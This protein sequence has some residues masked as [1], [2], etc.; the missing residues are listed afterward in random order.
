MPINIKCNLCDSENHID[1]KNIA[2]HKNIVQCNRCGLIF[3]N[4]MPDLETIKE[5]L[6]KVPVVSEVELKVEENKYEI[7]LEEIGSLN[8]NQ[9][10][11][12]LDI[13]CGFG[14]LLASAKK[15]GWQIFGL[16]INKFKVAFASEKLGI[17]IYCGELKE[18]EYL[19]DSFEV[20]TV[21]EV[22]EHLINPSG[23]LQ[24]INRILKKDGILVIVVPNVESFNAKTDPSWW[25]SYHFFHFSTNSL[26]QILKKNNLEV[27]KIIINPHLETRSSQRKLFLRKVIF[28][29]FSWGVVFIRK[30][31]SMRFVTKLVV[32]NKLM[33]TGGL[34]VYAKKIL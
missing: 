33:K 29:Y 9:K 3:T 26:T 5:E 15:R 1:Y 16:E 21:I 34:T 20:I 23:F 27:V 4:P 30:I 7:F 12:L 31:L 2:G 8:K 10:G 32:K 24:E 25:Q 18:A 28:E 22:L 6:Q 11:K 13:G 17:D 19:D 14:Q